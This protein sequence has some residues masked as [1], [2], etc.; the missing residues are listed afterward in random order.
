MVNTRPTSKMTI[1]PLNM[2]MKCLDSLPMGTRI[3]TGSP[4]YF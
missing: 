4:P 3:W 2:D 1:L